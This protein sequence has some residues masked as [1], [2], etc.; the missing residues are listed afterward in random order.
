VQADEA[1][2]CEPDERVDPA[3]QSFGS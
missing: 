3:A 2:D 1:H